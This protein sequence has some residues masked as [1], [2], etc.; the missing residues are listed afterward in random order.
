MDVG[1]FRRKEVRGEMDREE[2]EEDEEEEEE[3]EEDDEEEEVGGVF[4]GWVLVSVVSL[5]GLTSRLEF[6]FGRF[7]L[8][9]FWF[10]FESLSLPLDGPISTRR[11][12]AFRRILP[13]EEEA[14]VRVDEEGEKGKRR[15]VVEVV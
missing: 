9:T 14:E 13:R 4:D 10:M 12:R 3:E 11:D 1:G 15:V 7:E 8:L 5:S 6:V 2:A